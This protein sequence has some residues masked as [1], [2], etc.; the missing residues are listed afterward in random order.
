M[1]AD[2]FSYDW[3]VGKAPARFD[4]N[5][6][7]LDAHGEE[8]V[9]LVLIC[10]A[11]GEGDCLNKREQ[12]HVFNI[13]KKCA[14]LPGLLYAGRVSTARCVYFYFYTANA[15]LLYDLRDI[16][17]R[18]RALDCKADTQA[19]PEWQT[20]K[21]VLYPNAMKLQTELNRE[22]IEM[23][24]KHGDNVTVPR[25]V[26]F[27]V[28]FPS[29]VVRSA[30]SDEAKQNGFVIGETAFA[31]ETEEPYGLI[32]I[33]VAPLKKREMDELTNLVIYLAAPHGG[34]LR[35]WDCQSVPKSHPLR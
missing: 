4:V 6:A 34:S 27:H 32:L 11:K 8:D 16:A 13:E 10:R 2:W 19:E 9:M 5:R 28:Y 23:Y 30:F 25:R 12:R 21:Q 24:R 15:R 20:Y 18:E 1:Q 7:L 26:R 14:S 31:D 22:T 29:E 35:H 17:E 33:K 3:H